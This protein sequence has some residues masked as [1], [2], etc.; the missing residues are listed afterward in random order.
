MGHFSLCRWGSAKK[1]I[2][3]DTGK[4]RHQRRLFF[5]YW[6]FVFRLS[7]NSEIAIRIASETEMP[8]RSQISLRASRTESASRTDV[9]GIPRD[10]AIVTT[11]EKI[12]AWCPTLCQQ[13]SV[14]HI[15]ECQK[16]GS[17][18]GMSVRPPYE[19][20]AFGGSK[21]CARRARPFPSRGSPYPLGLKPPIGN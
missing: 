18:L 21:R 6:V 10:F 5:V 3:F 19:A 13:K 15:S 14:R 4:S 9:L 16:T 1:G 17:L 2:M 20:F 7:I 11:S 8:S 12:I